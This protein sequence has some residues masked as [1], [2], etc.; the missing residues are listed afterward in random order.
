MTQTGSVTDINVFV[1]ISHTYISDLLLFLDWGPYVAANSVQMSSYKCS[2]END[3]AVTFDDE[4]SST[5]SGKTCSGTPALTGDMQPQNP[6]SALDGK[7]ANQTWHLWA[8][9]DYSWDTGTI[10]NWCL[11]LRYTTP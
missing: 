8:F 10:D 7:S 11:T 3:I 4:S 2:Y 9:D 1:E 6:L 5:Y